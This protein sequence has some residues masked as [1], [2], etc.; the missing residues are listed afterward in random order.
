MVTEDEKSMKRA[1][2]SSSR[3]WIVLAL[4]LLSL[5]LSTIS[6]SGTTPDSPVSDRTDTGIVEADVAP[7]KFTATECEAHWLCQDLGRCAPQAD[8]C[9]A[10]SDAN[11]AA[12]LQCTIHGLCYFEG[13]E[14][15]ASNDS[16]ENSKACTYMGICKYSGPCCFFGCPPEPFFDEDSLDQVN[17][18]YENTIQPLYQHYCVPCHA[19]E[20]PSS[21]DGET[22]LASFKEAAM[23]PSYGCD[24]GI[25]KAECAL[26][27]IMFTRDPHNSRGL[28]TEGGYIIVPDHQTEL[29][30]AWIKAGFP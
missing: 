2:G 30:K 24:N 16:C 3:G 7:T 13:G 19:G 14:C 10:N 27:L 5:S 20:E 6:C 15:V 25:S 18:T 8:T 28:E 1:H 26:D 23:L 17:V 21:C 4:G 22:C 12:S 29:M 9:V 11:C